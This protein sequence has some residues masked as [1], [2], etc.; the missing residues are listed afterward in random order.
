MAISR[1]R[2]FPAEWAHQDA[3]MLTWPHKATAWASQLPEVEQVY[4][5]LA[6]AISHHENLLIICNSDSHRKAIEAKLANQKI[7]NAYFIIAPSN[8]TW[9]RDHGPIGIVD[10]EH[11]VLLDFQFNGWGGKYPSKLDNRINQS[12]SNSK[13]VKADVNPINFVLEGG[14]IE[15][16]GEGTLLTTRR[17]LLDSKRNPGMTESKMESLLQEWFGVERILWLDRG[18]LVGD[19]TDGHVDTLARFCDRKTIVYSSCDDCADVHYE[20]LQAMARELQAFKQVNGQPYRLLTLPLP[21]AQYDANG[22][23]LPATYANFLI[24]NH[25]VLVPV[26]ADPKSDQRALS[27]LAY[28]FPGY[29]IIG[30]NAIPLIQQYGSL[31]CVTMQLMLGSLSDP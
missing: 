3:V 23:R 13:I 8:D 10:H 19:D 28:A 25:A 6:Q 14:S 11:P 17:C 20:E 1:L 26:Y 29:E 5:N 2:H 27:T 7:T 9:T 24:I 31:H 18:K 12:L 22:K 30:I 21:R 16:D 4:L 15:S